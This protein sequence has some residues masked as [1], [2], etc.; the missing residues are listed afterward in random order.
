[1]KNYL[2]KKTFY[3]VCNNK[4]AH[5]IWSSFNTAE[6]ELDSKVF[7]MMLLICIYDA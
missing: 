1:M 5:H 3:D 7:T 2:K 4:K 6:V